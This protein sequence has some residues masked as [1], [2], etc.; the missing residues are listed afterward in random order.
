MGPWATGFAGIVGSAR[1]SIG[2]SLTVQYGAVSTGSRVAMNALVRNMKWIMLMSG[3]LTTTMIYAAIAPAAALRSNFGESLEGPL[4]E[5][6][7]RNWG[8]LIA[9]VGVMLIHAAFHPASRRV[10]LLVAGASKLAFIALVLSHGSRYLSYNAGVAVAIDA[11][12]VVL[13]AL[14]LASHREE[15]QATVANV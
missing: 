15:T 7:V 14:Y 12:T 4:A 8:I 13:F 11:A 9:L 5:L 3:L 6:I 1:R 10:A 2:R